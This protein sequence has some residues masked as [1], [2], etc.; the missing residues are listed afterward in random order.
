MEKTMES[1]GWIKLHRK[2]LESGVFSDKTRLKVWLW[3]LMKANHA[4]N[5]FA[6]NDQDMVLLPGQFI[7]GRERACLEL[8]DVTPQQYKTVMK[9]LKSTSRITSNSTNKYTVVTVLKWNEYQLINQ[10]ENQPTTSKQPA[11][12]QQITTNNNEKNVKNDKIVYRSLDFL[13]SLTEEDIKDF[14]LKFPSFTAEQIKEEAEK[15]HDWLQAMGLTRKNYKAYLRNWLR[16]AIA[17]KQRD[18]AQTVGIK[19]DLISCTDQEVW[20]TAIKLRVWLNE[21]K[22]KHTTILKKAQ[23]GTLPL[24]YKEY[25]NTLAILTAWLEED[26]QKGFVREW[27]QTEELGTK[28]ESPARVKELEGLVKF[29]EGAGKV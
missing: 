13:L 1:E 5:T 29:V 22:S 19:K 23:E 26:L 27:S 25:P 11:S 18:I 14:Q 16:N 3:V 17:Y 2:L 9:Y 15:S 6:F 21:V 28:S 20:E 24:R 4:K 8:Q 10:Q 12:N 7:T